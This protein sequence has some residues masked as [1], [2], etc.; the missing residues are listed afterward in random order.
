MAT[1]CLIHNIKLDT[2]KMDESQD[3]IYEE[4]EVLW[5]KIRGYPWWPAY[6]QHSLVQV[7]DVH[8]ANTPSAY[9]YTVI[10]FGDNTK[11]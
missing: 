7:S 9:E 2:H 8:E 6:V 1:A 11:Y 10:F 3:L 4:S 5:A